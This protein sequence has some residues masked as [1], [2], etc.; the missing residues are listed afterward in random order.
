MMR[1]L[2]AIFLSILL[3]A[4][5]ADRDT[6]PSHPI[7]L[8]CPWGNGGGTDLVSRQMALFLKA[9]LGVECNVIN[10]TGGQGVTGHRRGMLARPDG[11]T[12]A[13]M[14]FELNTMHWQGLTSLTHADAIP[15]IS[16][17]EDAAAIWVRHDAPWNSLDDLVA[18]IQAKPNSLKASGTAT[19]GAWHLALAGWLLE[20]K[21]S[22]S[23][24]LWIPNKGA[25]ASLQELAS[26]G[27]D[28]VCCSLPEAD[29]YYKNKQVRCLGVMSEETVPGFE[30]IPT[31]PSLGYTWTLIGW[32]GFGVPL[33]TPPER[34]QR[35]TD[36]MRRVV[37]GET[38]IEGKTFPDFM[39]DK[40]FNNRWRAGA[41]FAQFLAENDDKFGKL[42]SSPE[43]ASLSTGR[44]GPYLF[45]ALLGGCALVLGVIL[46]IRE[47][48]GRARAHASIAIAPAPEID[49]VRGDVN[50]AIALAGL[51]AYLLLS[52][53]IG[54]LPLSVVLV[55][56]VAWR[57]RAP[58]VPAITAALLL[59][60]AVYH[61]F[62]H[63][64]H[65]PLPRGWWGW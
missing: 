38:V 48:R 12:I 44:V 59:P 58:L 64:L 24:V 15:L 45:P 14:T 43:F 34:V 56:I 2:S 28:L 47:V 40:G 30:E 49:R 42:L 33:G 61:A 46:A 21:Q 41:D 4:G 18:A 31:F 5:C 39:H 10:A 52:E 1:I 60:L 16:V 19:G 51:C 29:R 63:W 7:T 62:V 8:V 50:V 53:T 65:V 9:E 20:L 25:E 35:L 11:E 54:F 27:I 17:N 13:V 57:L 55:G 22:A 36:A 37:T 32:R 26:G 6:F 3:L 23:A